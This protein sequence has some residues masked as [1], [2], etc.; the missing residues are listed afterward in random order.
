MSASAAAS[1]SVVL[2]HGG[3][4]DGSGWQGVCS[5]GC[6]RSARS[7]SSSARFSL[8]WQ[9]HSWPC[10]VTRRYHTRSELTRLSRTCDSSHRILVNQICRTLREAITPRP[11]A[12]FRGCDFRRVLQVVE[13]Q[14]NHL[15]SGLVT[16]ATEARVADAD[17]T[18]ANLRSHRSRDICTRQKGTRGRSMPRALS[19]ERCHSRHP[20]DRCFGPIETRL[21]CRRG[22]PPDS[23]PCSPDSLPTASGARN[24]SCSAPA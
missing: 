10:C 6:R 9:P 20:R 11:A 23:R 12:S 8:R 18:L 17:V 2:V 15:R 21:S 19:S 13:E 4:V 5:A 1:V 22:S 14:A 24:S 7:A 3:F 16:D